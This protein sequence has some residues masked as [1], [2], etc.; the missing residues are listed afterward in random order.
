MVSN[1]LKYISALINYL[2]KNK[3]DN[4]YIVFVRYEEHGKYLCLEFIVN[5]EINMKLQI[6]YLFLYYSMNLIKSFKR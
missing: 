6:D 3:T 4:S 2:D 5:W 1:Y